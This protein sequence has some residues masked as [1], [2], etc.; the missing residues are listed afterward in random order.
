MRKYLSFFLAVAMLVSVLAVPAFS[1]GYQYEEP[2]EPELWTEPDFSTDHDFSLAFVGDPQLITHGDY[3][4]GTKKLD[5]LFGSI[6]DTAQERKL[7]H[8]F[9][10]GDITH[11]GYHNDA[12]LAH[13]YVD[14]PVTAE[15]EI[16]RDA[17]F[18]MN[19]AN[20]PY[21]LCRGNHDDY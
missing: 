9:V 8:V 12:N 13:S 11:G 16:A 15:W 4:L 7:E 17:I 3:L 2:V 21:S 20:V 5:Q 19:A 10:L 18:Q 1:A 6:S 14:P